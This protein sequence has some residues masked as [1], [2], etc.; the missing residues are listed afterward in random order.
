M[1]GDESGRSE[2][3]ELHEGEARRGLRRR[4]GAA[5]VAAAGVWLA[6]P[7]C[8]NPRP[9]ELPSY[10]GSSPVGAVPSG[11]VRES[12]DDNPLLAGC[13]SPGQDPVGAGDFWS[14]EPA[15]APEAPESDEGSP[16]SQPGGAPAGPAPDA[17]AGDAGPAPGDG[18]VVP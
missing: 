11:P 5:L 7:G 4:L 15:A 3:S 6:A 2:G 17:G 18:S 16:D 13:D 8:L 14:D 10:D 9:E 1:G 12:C